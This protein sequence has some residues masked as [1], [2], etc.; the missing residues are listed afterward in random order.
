MKA[1]ALLQVIMT[2]LILIGVIV[3]TYVH[4]WSQTITW[5]NITVSS[6]FIVLALLMFLETKRDFN[7]LNNK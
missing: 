1:I 5:M 4:V 6:I 2:S 3:L 7:E